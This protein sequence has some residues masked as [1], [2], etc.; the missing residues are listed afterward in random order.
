MRCDCWLLPRL[1]V[2]SPINPGAIPGADARYDRSVLRLYPD[3]VLA[4]MLLYDQFRFGHSSSHHTLTR[5][6]HGT[7]K[8]ASLR[9]I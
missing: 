7:R 5:P 9:L 8:S 4:G 3:F 2:A 6:D 1:T